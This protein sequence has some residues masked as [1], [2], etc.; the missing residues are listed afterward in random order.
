MTI[1][2]REEYDG[3]TRAG[4]STYV[5]SLR[6]GTERWRIEFMF[7]AIYVRLGSISFSAGFEWADS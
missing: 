3:F 6:I 2:A 7:G 1:I 5:H 4:T